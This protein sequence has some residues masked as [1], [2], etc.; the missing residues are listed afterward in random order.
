MKIIKLATIAFVISQ[1]F[2]SCSEDEIQPP[3]YTPLGTY[4]SGVLILNEEGATVGTTPGSATISYISY[5]LKTIQ[6]NIFGLVNPSITLGNTAQSIGLNGNLAYIVLNGSDKIQIVNR[7]SF[8]N[9]SSITTGLNSPRYIAFANG[10]AYVTCWGD[11]SIATD[12]YVAVINLTNNTITTTIPVAEG[13]ERILEYNGKLYVS[14]RGG[15][16]FGNS[17][18]IINASTNS[19]LNSIIIGDVPN[20][21]AIENGA[22]WV[23]CE[24]KPI[25]ASTGQ[26]AGKLQKINLS[27][28]TVVT[29][30][31]FGSSGHPTNLAIYG[32][33]LY[34]T[35]DNSVYK[36]SH[37]VP[38]YPAT[39]I[40][41]PNVAKINTS[42]SNIYGF[43]VKSNRVYV[44]GFNAFTSNGTVNIYSIGEIYADPFVL[45]KS[46]T[47]GIGPNGF[48]F[49]M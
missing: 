28:N 13:P 2:I 7:Y 33:Y 23:L 45:L 22:L 36:M 40:E 9:V 44:S 17:I 25:Y 12:D 15:W 37:N 11:E 49:N 24:G 30:Y 32:N 8:A 3:F 41:L 20:T 14:H 10:N 48:Y 31:N 39:T 47:V 38:I 1:L 5:D 34:Y 27:T 29:S 35:I 18:S 16:G 42:F 43:A 6:N 26:T 21:M 4:D 46:Q 19:V